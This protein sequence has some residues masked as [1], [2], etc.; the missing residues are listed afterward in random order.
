MSA[1]PENK[2][3]LVTGGTGYIGVHTIVRLVS[4]GYYVTVVD[5]LVNSSAE[6]LDRV[7]HLTGCSEDQ[8]RF[9]QVDITNESALREVF[10]NSPAFKCCIHFAG[11]K[12]VGESVAKPLLYYENNVGGT[13]TL[14]KLMDEFR[15]RS[16]VFSSSATVRTFFPL[17]SYFRP[18][19]PSFSAL[20]AAQ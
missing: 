6:G 8:I 16:I 12:A 13:L 17:A 2:N 20:L 18:N 19:F 9:F 5:N 3:I 14:L 1:K 7:R 10:Q 11:L 4:T 15:C